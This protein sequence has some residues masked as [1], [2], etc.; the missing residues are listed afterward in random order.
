MT[1]TETSSGRRNR[2][3]E[4]TRARVMEA[5]IALMAERGFAALTLQAVADKA[6]VRYGNLTHHYGTRDV[7]VDAL[8]ETLLD[9]YRAQ[10]EALTATI[11]AAGDGSLR[12][13]VG[14][15]LDDAVT[16]E[17]GPVFLELWAMANHMP[18]VAAAMEE[19]YDEA[20]RACIKA[21]G[22]SSEAA[23]AS[24]LRDA[25]YLFGT[26]LEGSSAIFASRNR[27]TD[28]YRGFRGEAFELLVGILECRLEKARTLM[29]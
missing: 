4:A 2:S 18:S 11:A 10:F 17:T 27:D 28:I 3:G 22:V 6:E 26:V 13:V 5:A 23:V 14:W 21:L 8:L 12:D 19:L 20:V 24:G 25:L 15:L 7:L 29:G 16:L 9:R 1:E